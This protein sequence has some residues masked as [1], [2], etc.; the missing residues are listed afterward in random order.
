MDAHVVER[1]EFLDRIVPDAPPARDSIDQVLGG[2]HR[3]RG[4][5]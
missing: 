3:V 4:Q 1:F 2:R 5:D